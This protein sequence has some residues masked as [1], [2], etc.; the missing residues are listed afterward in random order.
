MHSAEKDPKSEPLEYIDC[1]FISYA[2]DNQP[3]NI[4]EYG[5]RIVILNRRLLSSLQVTRE[6]EEEII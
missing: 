1:T 3:T 5:T 6:S 2:T 4:L